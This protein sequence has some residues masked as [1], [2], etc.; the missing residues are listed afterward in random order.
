MTIKDRTFL[1]R[2]QVYVDFISGDQGVLVNS[3]S[4]PEVA[5]KCATSLRDPLRPNIFVTR[6]WVVD[7][8]A[9]SIN[10]LVEG[11]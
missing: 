10:R 1:H 8:E 11:A 6:A 4:R 7:T 3:Y 9:D 5:E 2:Y